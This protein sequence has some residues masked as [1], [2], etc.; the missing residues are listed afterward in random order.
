M[1]RVAQVVKYSARIEEVAGSMA[2]I[3]PVFLS[4][5]SFVRPS[6]VPELR[7]SRR[8]E[9]NLIDNL[10]RKKRLKMALI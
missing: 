9:K 8:N 4:R 5:E 2:A 1:D 10:K 3:A 6:R 7:H